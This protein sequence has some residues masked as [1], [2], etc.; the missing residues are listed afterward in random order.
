MIFDLIYST[1]YEDTNKL[2]KFYLFFIQLGNF[3]NCE[4]YLKVGKVK[5][6]NKKFKEYK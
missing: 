3:K 5:F 6:D 2:F 4:K 1:N